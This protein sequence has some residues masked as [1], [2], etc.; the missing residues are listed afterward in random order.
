MK[1]IY[2]NLNIFDIRC[3][4]GENTKEQCSCISVVGPSKTEW[5]AKKKRKQDE[6]YY[7]DFCCLLAFSSKM[8]S[9]IKKEDF[10]LK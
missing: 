3:N 7:K 2:P 10:Q 1:I 6:G 5:L 4:C 8:R 9:K